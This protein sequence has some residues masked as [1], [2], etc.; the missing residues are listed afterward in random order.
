MDKEKTPR[1]S[2]QEGVLVAEEKGDDVARLAAIDAGILYAFLRVDPR[3]AEPLRRAY[4]TVCRLTAREGATAASRML[5]C[6]QHRCGLRDPENL[7]AEREWARVMVYRVGDPARL[8]DMDEARFNSYIAEA[9]CATIGISRDRAG[10]PTLG[11]Q[12]STLRGILHVALVERIAAKAGDAQRNLASI[13]IAEA[14]KVITAKRE[15]R[16]EWQKKR[17]AALRAEGL[18]DKRIAH[19]LNVDP[20][21]IRNW[22]GNREQG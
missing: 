4:C 11:V 10:I 21:T 15:S 16:Q 13:T 9:G 22:L 17:A 5:T 8:D 2:W 6:T 14:E 7:C 1:A 18:A 19:Q 3:E 20:K 12:A